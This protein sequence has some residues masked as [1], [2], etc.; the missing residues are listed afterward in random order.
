MA[1]INW[2]MNDTV[3]PADLNQIGQEINDSAAKITQHK[4][5]AVL[6]HPDKSVTTSKLADKGV[7]QAK[8]ADKAVGSGQ[9]ADGAATDTVIG[10]RTVSDG[11]APTADSGT[12][13][14]LFSGLAHMIKAITGGTTWRTLPSITLT[15]I[16]TILDAATNL[17]TASTLLKRDSAGRAKVAAPAAV[18]DIARKAEVDAVQSNLTNHTGDSSQHVP[19]IG[20]GNSGKVL[21]AGATA[22]SAAW[23][24]VAWGEVTG[25]PS[26]FAPSSHDHS[27]LQRI[28]D[29]DRKPVDATKGFAEFV[30]TSLEGMTGEAG[31]SNYQD[32]IVLNMYT[33]SSGGKVNALV[34]D[35]TNM[36]IRHYQAAQDATT[37]GDPRVIAYLDQMPTTL[38]ANGGNA[39][40]VDGLHAIDFS[41]ARGGLQFGGVQTAMTTSEFI[42]ML[43]SLGAFESKYWVARGS[44]SYAKNQFISDTGV[45]NIHLAGC[46]VEVI[47]A[48]S[49]FYTIRITTP[50]ASSNGVVDTEFIYSSNG[51]GYAARW[52]KQWNDKNDGAGSGLDADLLDGYQTSLTTA[53]N[54]VPVRGAAGGIEAIRYTST[55]ET[56]AQPL[57]ISSTTRVDNLNVD[58]VDGFH[59][60]QDLRTTAS[61][62]FA[63]GN[64]E[65]ISVKVGSIGALKT[66]VLNL[67]NTPET[68]TAGR[69][70]LVA[71]I[72]NAAIPTDSGNSAMFKGRAIIDNSFGV[73]GNEQSVV[74]FTFGVRPGIKPAFF[75]IGDHKPD[76]RIYKKSDGYH[77]LYVWQGPFSKRVIFNYYSYNCLEYWYVENPAAQTGST[78]IWQSSDGA[79]Q[80]VYVGSKKVLHGGDLNSSVAQKKLKLAQQNAGNFWKVRDLVSFK[81]N[82]SLIKGALKIVLPVGWTNT[83]MA[84]Y[85]HGINYSGDT[86]RAWE[87]TIF[88]YNYDGGSSGSGAAAWHKTDVRTLGNVPFDTVRFGIE[89]G[90]CIILI[91]S[92]TTSWEYAAVEVT[93]ALFT[94]S[95][96]DAILE[97]NDWNMTAVTSWDSAV[98]SATVNKINNG[99]DADT[100]DGQHGSYY[101]DASN[102]NAGTVPAARLPAATT[103]IQGAMSA[104]D[105]AKLDGIATGANNYVHPTGDGNQHVPATGTSNSGRVLK[106]GSTAGSAAWSTLTKAD[107]SDFPASLPANGGNAD[108]L[109]GQHGSY[110]QNADNINAGTLAIDRLPDFLVP[111]IRWKSRTSAAENYW[112]SVCY[113]N[114]LFVAVSDSGTGNRVMT[115][116]DGVIWTSRTSAADQNWRSV[117][118]GNGLFVAVGSSGAVMTSTN[119]I[120]WT[121]R[122]AA[123]ANDWH[124]VC[125]GNGLFVAVS[126]SG[127]GNRVM[128][129]TNGI[130][131][132]SRTSAADHYWRS[133]CYGNGLFVAVSSSGSVMTSSDGITW[134]LRTA[135]SSIT[136]FGVCYGNGLF[137][138]V[139]TSGTGNRVMTSTNGITWTSR[140][141]AADHDWNAVCYGNGLFVA[142]NSS[143]KRTVMTSP[144]GITWTLR[145]TPSSNTWYAV[146]YAEG[147]FV[148]VGGGGGGGTG[149]RVMTSGFA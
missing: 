102:L 120:T 16:K 56:G 8:I 146:C 20:T 27:R 37:W 77:Y 93:E 12:V 134:T 36:V 47:S 81:T 71:R 110:Y 76:F 129:S 86:S 17:A 137:V 69:W 127:T 6:D 67:N 21:K 60:D 107:I 101:R 126:T 41:R 89:N 119:G 136:W 92:N 114:G 13:T 121:S 108:T 61:P 11:T 50:S 23:G 103:S 88:G 58:M 85:L 48:T 90:K 55:A 14:G 33:D 104:S 100:I 7:T 26:S 109:D 106:A 44:W 133:V 63:G 28:D 132:T 138:A 52:R 59:L 145:T 57:I 124:G 45:G 91:G 143:A 19:A 82:S 15:A 144:D 95:A 40:T 149:D 98:I 10:S 54:T 64:F 122:T 148:A 4:T 46:T 147:V 105:K 78:L 96:P 1:K 111:G 125:Y 31:R 74:D 35:K 97:S 135:A 62:T 84:L 25:K 142:V 3:K 123:T 117:C 79:T 38:P 128:T 29:R 75:V 30:F 130:T 66:K 65:E 99:I 9:L 51:S 118:Y 70:I 32:M 39:D 2:D 53:P 22:G 115:S 116:L 131:W 72:Q 80:D 34:L 87:A 83:M 24:E 73:S 112:M 68:D 140:T 18:D 141:S 42:A 49:D 5:A 113:G 139:S 94:H 43:T